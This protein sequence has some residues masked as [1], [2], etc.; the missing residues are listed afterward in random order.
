MILIRA[1]QRSWKS[2]IV[3]LLVT[4][5]SVSHRLNLPSFIWFFT[6]NTLRNLPI[7]Y[8]SM[9]LRKLPFAK[10][11]SFNFASQL[12]GHKMIFTFKK[13]E[14]QLI[15]KRKRGPERT[16]NGFSFCCFDLFV[17]C[18]PG[19]I[20]TLLFALVDAAAAASEQ[21]PF[22]PSTPNASYSLLHASKIRTKCITNTMGGLVR[23]R[24]RALSSVRDNY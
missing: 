17:C 24:A 19:S 20:P 6:A 1:N 23:V 8:L 4:S 18:S 5:S 3:L 9:V 10:C 21:L 15:E 2:A 22:L 11:V 7:R 16:Q 12:S 13:W 14:K